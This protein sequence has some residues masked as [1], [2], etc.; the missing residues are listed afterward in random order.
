MLRCVVLLTFLATLPAVA[1]GQSASIKGRVADRSTGRPVTHA[2]LTIVGEER[3][4][5]TDSLGLYEFRRVPTGVLQI[6]VRA[7]GFPASSFL[8]EI[9]PGQQ[10]ER[11]VILDRTEAQ[12]LPELSVTAAAP[13]TNYRLVDFERRRQNGRGQF[14]TEDDILRS[15]AGSVADAVKNMRGVVYECG[16]GA[17]CYVRMVR[18]PMRCLPEFVVDGQVM[19]D[20]GPHTP[21]RDIVALEVYN[22]PADVPGEFAGRNSGCG[23]LVLHTRSGPTRK[24][25]TKP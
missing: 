2:E 3:S 4:T 12:A 24:K 23:V 11:P 21:I 13:T 9:L 7:L 20:F 25:I 5:R 16:G 18:A 22:G 10:A 1:R 14:L 6:N 15:G 19:N 17:G 8:I